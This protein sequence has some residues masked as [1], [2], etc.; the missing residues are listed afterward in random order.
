MKAQQFYQAGYED[1]QRLIGQEGIVSM[2]SENEGGV[3]QATGGTK[4]D[5]LRETIRKLKL[6]LAKAE[7]EAELNGGM[8]RAMTNLEMLPV[9]RDQL[10]KVLGFAIEQ[11]AAATSRRGM[12]TWDFEAKCARHPETPCGAE[13]TF[14][15]QAVVQH[16]FQERGVFSTK[17]IMNPD[18]RELDQQ[19]M[20]GSITLQS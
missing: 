19:S 5:S 15:V 2:P 1:G 18:N 9:H 4:Q 16:D 12:I 13:L 7:N 14:G 17:I 8:L 3:T 11:V 20:G 6:R 10:M